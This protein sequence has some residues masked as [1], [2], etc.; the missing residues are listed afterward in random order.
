MP[1]DPQKFVN[2][3]QSAKHND[4]YVSLFDEEHDVQV[5]VFS[6]IN[7]NWSSSTAYGAL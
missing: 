3:K 2:R 1:G 7:Y 5:D 4:L 6:D